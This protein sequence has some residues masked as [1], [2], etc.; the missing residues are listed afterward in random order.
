[1]KPIFLL[2]ILT[3]LLF[4]AFSQEK[5]S[6]IV[7]QNPSSRLSGLINIQNL[8]DEGNSYRI[9]KFEGNWA[10]VEIGINGFANASY[11]LYPTTA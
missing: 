10:G 9:D 11:D 8:G 6:V 2:F 4:Q 7:V 5:D 1:M 3:G